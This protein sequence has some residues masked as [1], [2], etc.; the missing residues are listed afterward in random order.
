M[1]TRREISV[2]QIHDYPSA[3]PYLTLSHMH[4]DKCVGLDDFGKPSFICN[5]EF[6]CCTTCQAT[7]ASA[8]D[9]AECVRVRRDKARKAGCDERRYNTSGCF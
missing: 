2:A 8:T 5:R 9:M 1:T 6:N 7:G 3:F 4:S